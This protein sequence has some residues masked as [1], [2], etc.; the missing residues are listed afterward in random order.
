MNVN[1][2]RSNLYMNAYLRNEESTFVRESRGSLRVPPLG[3]EQEP[4][5]DGSTP[6]GCRWRGVELDEVN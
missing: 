3:K 4:F 2:C 5:G 1:E 6:S